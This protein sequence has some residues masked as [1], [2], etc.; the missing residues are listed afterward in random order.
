[1]QKCGEIITIVGGHGV[2][3]QAG[4]ATAVGVMAGTIGGVIVGEVA[5]G[6]QRIGLMKKTGYP[7]FFIGANG[8][9]R[10]E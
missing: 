4:V 8:A 7:V 2:H 5:G 6:S 10:G 1:V 9:W 3:Q